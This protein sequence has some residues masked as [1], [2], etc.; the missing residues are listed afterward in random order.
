MS[1]G[2]IKG[3]FLRAPPSRGKMGR[4]LAD[5]GSPTLIRAPPGSPA[6]L[7]ASASKR[8]SLNTELFGLYRPWSEVRKAMAT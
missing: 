5:E 3:L 4:P 8:L 1:T 6:Q 7:R 2:Y